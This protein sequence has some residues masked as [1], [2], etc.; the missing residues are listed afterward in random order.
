MPGLR[1]PFLQVS[2]MLRGSWEPGSSKPAM[3]PAPHKYLC[4][5]ARLPTSWAM[6]RPRSGCSYMPWLMISTL[7]SSP[8]VT[9]I[10][11]QQRWSWQ[12]LQPARGWPSAQP[13]APPPRGPV[14]V[15]LAQ[16]HPLLHGDCLGEQQLP[17]RHGPA[18]ELAH[19]DGGHGS[20]QGLP[21]A[22][23]SERGPL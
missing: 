17:E 9:G 18:L 22:V 11:T 12:W 15:L 16:R 14:L 19:G 23:L 8:G 13:P 5:E 7:R 2:W 21:G 6:V 4:T 10:L 20:S 3:Q 1:S